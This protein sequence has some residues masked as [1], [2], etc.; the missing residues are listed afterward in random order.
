M[1]IDDLRAR[2]PMC[3]VFVLVWRPAHGWRL[4]VHSERVRGELV[5]CCTDDVDALPLVREWIEMQQQRAFGT[6]YSA[7]T[8]RAAQERAR[9][10]AEMYESAYADEQKKVDAMLALVEIEE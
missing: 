2:C 8:A 7:R 4:R 5:S 3:G 1:T 9:L 6:D 10:D